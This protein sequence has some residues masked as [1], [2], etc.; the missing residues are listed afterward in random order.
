MGK[1]NC[2]P[3]MSSNGHRT[4]YVSNVILRCNQSTLSKPA[5]L[6]RKTA[7]QSSHIEPK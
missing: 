4:S 5:V 7:Q 6:G 2:Y 1:I 3:Y